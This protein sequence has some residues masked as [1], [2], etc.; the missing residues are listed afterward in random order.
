MRFT[1]NNLDE[2]LPR[3]E[4]C[5]S[6]ATLIAVSTKPELESSSLNPVIT[7]IMRV[8]QQPRVCVAKESL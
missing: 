1:S 7:R 4:D 3:N 6:R 5:F 8:I 2:H